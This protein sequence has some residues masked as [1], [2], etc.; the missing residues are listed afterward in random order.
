MSLDFIGLTF[1]NIKSD[2]E[3]FLKKEHNKASILY[4][5]A[6]PYGQILSVLENMHQLS[7]MYLKNS[8][9]QFD[10]GNPNSLNRR[11]IRNAAISVGHNP[12]RATSATGTLKFRVKSSS[13]IES[14]ISGSKITIFNR[15][16]IRNKSNSLGYIMNI[17][18]EKTTHSITPN[19]SFFV[20][21][22]Q[23]EW[24]SI[25]FTGTDENYQ[26][27]Q[28]SEQGNVDIENFN[29]EVIVDGDLWEIKNHLYEM[30]PDEKACVVRTG[31]NN[32]IDIIFGNGG[33]GKVPGI[34]SIIEVNYIVTNGSNGNLFSRSINDWTILDDVIDGSG[35]VVDITNL[36]DISIFTDINFGSDSESI[37]FTKN[38]LPMSSNNYVLA[39]PQQYA[40]HIKRLG[41]FTHV[42]AYEENGSIF[43]TVT[44]NVN[45]FK[46]ANADYFTIDLDAFILDDLEKEKIDQYLRAQGTI[47]LTKKY[48]IISPILSFYAVNISYISYSDATDDSIRAQ[49][50]STLSDYF[51][52]LNSTNR[53]PRS[54]LVRLITTNVKDIHSIDI[55]FV[56]KKNEDYH[57]EQ[58][59][60]IENKL[61]NISSNLSTTTTIKDDPNYNRNKVL[62]IDPVM[63][64]IVF[65]PNEIPLIRGGWKDR[66]GNLYSDS[67]DSLGLKSVNMIRK[68]TIDRKLK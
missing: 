53:I 49:V 61:K 52:N 60:I 14:E 15:T 20:P 66:N 57:G 2:V 65:E 50:L 33:F 11:Y 26:S 4:S 55:Q 58:K 27:F 16:A 3:Y 18:V 38:I 32:G 39:L 41:V 24:K 34:G 48:K 44:P 22:I 46:N 45:L 56:S 35:E 28:V 25:T 7:F 68:G 21:I 19:Y 10:L 40:Y 64:D 42:N 29:V 47:Q 37:L 30:I 9:N 67:I 1:D 8:L 31:Y 36:F 63:G 51:L 54:E 62:G 17:G 5:N 13:D 43:I 12:S 59:K 6:S 23:G